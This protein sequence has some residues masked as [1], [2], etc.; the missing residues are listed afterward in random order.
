MSRHRRTRLLPAAAAVLAFALAGCGANASDSPATTDDPSS[1]G[2]TT[3]DAEDST[4]A[5]PTELT[6]DESADAA[7]C[8]VPN[9]E[10]LATQTTAF[11]GTVTDVADGTATLEV[12]RWFEGEE[13]EQVSVTAPGDDAPALLTAVEFEVGSTYLV[14]AVGDQV[15]LCGFS[16][17]KTPELEALYTAAFAS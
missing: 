14:S 4:S 9:A 12:D 3:S 6:I 16:A 5:G 8:M 11:E 1:A 15:S 13:S 7:R 17:E 2:T 10:T